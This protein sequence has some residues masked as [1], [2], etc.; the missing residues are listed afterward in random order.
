MDVHVARS[1]AAL[2]PRHKVNLPDVGNEV[3]VQYAAVIFREI[4]PLFGEKLRVP[5]IEPVFEY[6]V[7]VVDKFRVAEQLKG[8]RLAGQREVTAWLAAAGVEM[9]M[10]G[11]EWNRE[12]AAS[13]PLKSP[14]GRALIPDGRRP[15][16]T[17]IISS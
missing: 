10:P 6:I 17:V 1:F 2:L 5:G 8:D 3:R 13:F 9:L 4:F 15:A 16:A 7:G 12:G 11:V 14:L